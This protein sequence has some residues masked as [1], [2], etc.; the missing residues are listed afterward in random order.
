MGSQAGVTTSNGESTL[1]FTSQTAGSSGALSVTSAI[2][3]TA[4]TPLSFADAGYTKTTADSGT[5]GTVPAGT[6]V[7]SGSMTIQV[8][9]GT[10]ESIVIGAAP[11]SP[12]ANTIYTGSG[13]DTL[14]DV[15][16]AIGEAGLGVSVALD[17]A[18]TGLTLT[19]SA[20]GAAGALAVTSSI[21]DTT[22]PTNTTLNYND[23]SDINNLTS[24]GISVNN[25]GSLTFDA[26]FARFPAQLGL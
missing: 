12:A 19:S 8:G 22:S 2:V 23:S 18:G 9:G 20:V 25:D 4:P 26:Q 10:T 13:A 11:S 17:G 21:V 16:S 14:S 6:D 3:A 1:T 5:F 24:L 7:L 15:M